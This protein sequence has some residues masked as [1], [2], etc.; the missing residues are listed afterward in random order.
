MFRIATLAFGL[1]SALLSALA[2][3][4]ASAQEAPAFSIANQSFLDYYQKRG[5][6]RTFGYP[7][8]GQF[9]LLGFPVQLFQRAVLQLMPDGHVATMNLLDPGM[10]PYTSF[11][12][13]V[14]PG[15]QRELADAAPS[16]SDPDY[17]RKAI[18]FVAAN[19]P[20]QWEGLPVG[21]TRTFMS[22]VRHEDA[23]PQGGGAPSLVPLLNLELWG[24]PT[25]RPT[26]DP[27]N[28]DFV[29][30]RFQRGIMHYDATN[31]VT[32]GL[33]LGDYF[34]AILTGQKLPADVA[35]EATSS[36]FYRQYDPATGRGPL[37]PADLAGTE[38][39]G[40][41]RVG[42]G[43]PRFGVVVAGPGTDD[44]TYVASS[45]AALGAG[46][47]YSFPGSPARVPG[48]VE[49]VRPGADLD[50]LSSRARANPG[51]A[52]L[53]GNEPNVPGQDDLQP[54]AYADFLRKVSTAIKG[55]DPTAV[56][57]GPNV[58]NW[59]ATCTS[60]P[61][62][63]AG[64]AWSEAF[65][66]SY[67][68]RYGPLPLDVW[69]IHAYSLDWDHLPLV[70]AA[71]DQAQVTGAREWL[72]SRGLQLHLW[73]T[74]F[75]VIWGFDGV[76][77]VERDGKSVAVPVGSFRDDLVGGYV[78]EMLSWLSRSSLDGL[79]DRWFLYATAPPPEPYASTTAGI[80]LLQPG[81]LTLTPFGERYR[82]RAGA[83]PAR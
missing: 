23:F 50:E 31:G 82:T 75:G 22:T 18:E 53:I 43:D 44:P 62:F 68:E 12:Y 4:R 30:L 5:G 78:D 46:S 67:Q 81:T 16:P 36:P 6:L 57:V 14:V 42:L 8:S 83:A 47:W 13:S 33:L 10:M 61:G 9:T 72:D 64:R 65:L 2:P 66:N 21:F 25:S 63:P 55:A 79:V 40:A 15:P 37:R 35:A 58:L 52:W 45:L 49:L 71:A 20:D 26:R 41:F 59:D 73:L 19:A 34:K 69:G 76:Q 77:W 29:Y 54:A 28:G 7:V 74:E 3:V 56:L 24:L 39:D 17:A 51:T 80:S 38:L 70:N 11:N 32:Q 27:N 1:V 48:R 60:C